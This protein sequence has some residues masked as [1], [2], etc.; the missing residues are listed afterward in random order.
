MA[1]FTKYPPTG[2]ESGEGSAPE[3]FI[4]ESQPVYVDDMSLLPLPE[5]AYALGCWPDTTLYNPVLLNP[6]PLLDS[7]SSFSE[8]YLQ[9]SCRIA[10]ETSQFSPSPLKG[11]QYSDFD[12]SMDDTLVIDVVHCPEDDD[13]FL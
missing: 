8:P 5:P 7:S 2:F 1:V 13:V 11:F 4:A 10:M 6:P 9:E 12:T 3:I